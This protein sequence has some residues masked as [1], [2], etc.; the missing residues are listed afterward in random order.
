MLENPIFL[1][2]MRV[3]LPKHRGARIGVLTMASV[4]LIAVYLRMITELAQRAGPHNSDADILW[5]ILVWAQFVFVLFAA[6]AYASNA[7]SREK[8]QQTWDLL[9]M[10]PLTASEIVFGKLLG[11][12]TV[13]FL[14]IVIILPLEILIAFTLGY[15]ANGLF[16]LTLFT[17][18]IF[19]FFFVSLSL[20]ASWCLSR[21]LYAQIVSYT[22]LIGVLSIGTAL[23]TAAALALS[24]IS[25]GTSS[26][27]FEQPWL[28]LN[29]FYLF[30]LLFEQPRDHLYQLGI[31]LLIYLIIGLVMIYDIIHNLRRHRE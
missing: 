31:G 19:T 12:L 29:P 15:Y 8:E 27:T 4:F 25:A 17:L 24:S 23:L 10:T 14:P 11:R 26:S 6:P 5:A 16:F 7:F 20:Y 13:F 18:L 3:R 9:L 2:E 30:S 28:W 1:R 21:T 22:V